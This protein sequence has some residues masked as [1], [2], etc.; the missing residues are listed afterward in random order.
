MMVF[1]STILG[2]TA[3]TGGKGNVGGVFAAVLAIS[4]IENLMNLHGVPPSI[5]QEVYCAVLLLAIYL[6]SLQEELRHAR[7]GS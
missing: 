1:A 5:R 4:I 7:M 6:A 3:L 2:G